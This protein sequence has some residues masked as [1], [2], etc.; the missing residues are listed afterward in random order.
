MLQTSAA[1]TTVSSQKQKTGES[2]SKATGEK[3]TSV[4]SMFSLA[5]LAEVS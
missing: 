5:R 4:Q 2:H 3:G 1:T